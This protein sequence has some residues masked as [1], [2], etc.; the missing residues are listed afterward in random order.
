MEVE[1][2]K[3]DRIDLKLILLEL[4]DLVRNVSHERI[5]NGVTDLD[6]PGMGDPGPIEAPLGVSKLLL[7]GLSD[8]FLRVLGLT[9]PWDKR[10]DASYGKYASLMSNVNQSLTVK[11][12]K[13]SVNGHID[14]ELE[15]LLPSLI[16][17][18]VKKV[19][20]FS[21]VDWDNL[22]SKCEDNFF[23]VDERLNS[24][25]DNWDLDWARL[26]A[27]VAFGLRDEVC[28][29]LCLFHGL[30]LGDGEVNAS[31]LGA[32]LLMVVEEVE[33]EVK[34]SGGERLPSCIDMCFFFMQGPDSKKD[35][36]RGLSLQFIHLLLLS[37]VEINLF[38][39]GKDE[40]LMA[41]KDV[42]PGG[43]EGVLQVGH[44]GLR[45]GVQSIDDVL[46]PIRRACDLHPSLLDLLRDL[47]NLP[48]CL[49]ESKGLWSFSLGKLNKAYWDFEELSIS[50]SGFLR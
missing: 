18:N 29:P 1:V 41:G 49:S 23:N 21:S 50:G 17:Q 14:R 32:E 45:P 22:L 3:V 13:R 44:V 9:F 25:E 27:K 46:F 16:L 36:C 43:G 28:E 10:R 40:V 37:I 48:S 4:V 47:L 7:L 39:A 31:L 6:Q 26:D 33:G 12:H 19:I 2:Q 42:V 34:K 20:P 38:R 30:N 8:G 15:R 35:H 5:V 24:L 11:L